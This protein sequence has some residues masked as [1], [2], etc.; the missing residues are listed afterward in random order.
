MHNA[1]TNNP[2]ITARRQMA[3]PSIPFVRHHGPD[4]P[5]REGMLSAFSFFGVT[6]W[7]PVFGKLSNRYRTVTVENKCRRKLPIDP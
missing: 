4:E 1:Q 6:G 5:T 2:V 7:Q 3:A